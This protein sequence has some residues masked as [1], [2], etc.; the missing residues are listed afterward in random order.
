MNVPALTAGRARSPSMPTRLAAVRSPRAWLVAFVLAAL[1]VRVAVVIATPHYVA[2]TDAADF[3]Q[4]AV[5]LA[6][7]GHYPRS[8]EW[9][10]Q[11]PTAFRPPLFPFALAVVDKLVGTGSEHARWTADR[12][13]EAV[14][15]AIAVGLIGLIGWRVWGAAVA[16]VAAGIAAIDPPLLL[17]GSSLLSEALFIP[18]VLG[19]VLAALVHRDSMHRRRLAVLSGVL[20]GLAALTRGNGVVVA[21]PAVLLLWGTRPRWRWAA[22]RAPVVLLA[23]AALTMLPWAI[24]NYTEFH[25][26]VPT[27]TET[28]YALAGTYNAATQGRAA[29]P[30][31]WYP[32]L[33]QMKTL[34]RADPRASEAVISSRLTGNALRYIEHHPSSLAKTGYYGVVRL[35]NL[36]G[37]L[38]EEI[39]SFGEGYPVRLAQ[40]SVYA[41]WV[42]LALAIAGAL[43]PAARRAPWAL[44]ACPAVIMLSAVLLEGLTRY[45]LPADP[46]FVLL[47]ALTLVTA[48]RRL[49]WGSRPEPA[50]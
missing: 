50:R 26:V 8:H 41:F 43:T 49:P 39:L 20:V 16:L 48:A 14:L 10:P 30:T 28:G 12:I 18:L 15:G 1:L 3:D 5:S 29:V 13:M 36:N 37:P 23:A 32:P 25:R 44:W 33:E 42:L 4:L 27:T 47:A 9:A 46:F 2:R 24:R 19:A 38:L 34:A 6:S 11:G 7:T 17:A 21:I 40:Y 45:R 22:L 35:L 31:L